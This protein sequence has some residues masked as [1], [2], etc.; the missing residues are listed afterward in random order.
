MADQGEYVMPTP[1]HPTA[2]RA[3]LEISHCAII[4]AGKESDRT[5]FEAVHAELHEGPA[6]M[7]AIP[8]R[9]NPPR[10]PVPDAGHGF[11]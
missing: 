11:W 3:H 10:D 8:H 1:E 6:A 7:G 4:S 2:W 5:D 9:H